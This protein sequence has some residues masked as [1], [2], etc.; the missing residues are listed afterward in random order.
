MSVSL[1]LIVLG[2][3][4]M[5]TIYGNQS[6]ESYLIPT[7]A[8][9]VKEQML[10]WF[11]WWTNKGL[12]RKVQVDPK[13]SQ[14]IQQCNDL[15]SSPL[16]P[17]DL[18]CDLGSRSSFSG[19]WTSLWGPFYLWKHV[20]WK[21]CQLGKQQGWQLPDW[22]PW[23]S[24]VSLL[25]TCQSTWAA[26]GS[27]VMRLMDPLWTGTCSVPMPTERKKKTGKQKPS[28]KSERGLSWWK[29]SYWWPCS[30]MRS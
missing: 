23:R 19:V 28:I 6:H 16:Y 4:D 27:M 24:T 25:W 12:S 20:S 17:P 13:R 7:A 26:W 21:A 18:L 14:S 5:F 30:V 11:Y 3:K 2:L 15:D 8:L 29:I 22:P 10:V 9:A 1:V